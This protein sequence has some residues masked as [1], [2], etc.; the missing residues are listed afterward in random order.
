MAQ[1]HWQKVWINKIHKR[2]VYTYE[3]CIKMGI[4]MSVISSN[5]Q[6]LLMYTVPR[7]YLSWSMNDIKIRLF[8]I[9]SC[10]SLVLDFSDSLFYLHCTSAKRTEHHFKQCYSCVKYLPLVLMIPFWWPAEGH[11]TFITDKGY[12]EVQ[13]SFES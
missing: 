4:S 12:V 9:Q 8:R 10:N 13:A 6:I 1:L 5:L 11:L 7:Y 3:K 2:H